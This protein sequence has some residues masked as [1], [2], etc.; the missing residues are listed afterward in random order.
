MNNDFENFL[1]WAELSGI[2]LCD[3]QKQIIKGYFE[4]KLMIVP[5]QCGRTYIPILKGYK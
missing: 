2:E 1:K 5:R 4:N 3:Y